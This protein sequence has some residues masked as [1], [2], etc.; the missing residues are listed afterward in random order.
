MS[1]RDHL[2][3]H[4]AAPGAQ[5]VDDS[6]N[7]HTSGRDTSSEGFGLNS[8]IK[9]PKRPKKKRTRPDCRYKAEVLKCRG[10][11]GHEMLFGQKFNEQGAKLVLVIMAGLVG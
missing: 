5:V 4:L 7:P 3:Q 11:M 10:A 2:H 8:I 6:H 9:K 1:G